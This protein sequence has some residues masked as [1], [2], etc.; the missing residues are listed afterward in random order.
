MRLRQGLD[1]AARWA[2]PLAARASANA[3]RFRAQ[4]RVRGRRLMKRP[5]PVPLFDDPKHLLAALAII[6][7][8][9]ALLDLQVATAARVSG[10]PTGFF[11]R[12]TDLGLSGLVLVPTGIVFLL[13]L[14][15]DPAA[16]SRR[17]GV[18]I[19]TIGGVA[20]Y[21]FIAVGLSGLLAMGLKYAIGRPRPKLMES[22]GG[23]DLT[24]FTL[25]AAHASFPSGHATSAAAFAVAMA[26]FVPRWR[27][28]L[29]VFAV[30]VAMSRVMIG[31]HFP[32]DVLAGMLFGGVIAHKVAV[33]ASRR[34]L[35]FEVGDDGTIKARG[36]RALAASGGPVGALKLITEARG[37]AEARASGA[38]IEKADTKHDHLRSVPTGDQPAAA[39]AGA[40]GERD[41]SVSGRGG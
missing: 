15:I 24:P 11:W 28:A 23:F 2:R 1:S 29:A 19:A 5:R 6:V 33:A 36:M 30:V 18:T 27:A 31:V 32:S 4:Y 35:V 39:D 13:S 25:E 14:I 17:A 8:V 37:V 3:D 16:I 40:G 7:V 12:I 9:A 41:R 26:L 20:G 22:V 21:F 34:R 38:A 10:D